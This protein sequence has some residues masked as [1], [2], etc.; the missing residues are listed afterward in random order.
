[1]SAKGLRSQ[2]VGAWASVLAAIIASTTMR[3]LAA[4]CSLLR[5]A[6]GTPMGIEGAA[7]VMVE[8]ETFM[9]RDHGVW[10]AVLLRL[11]D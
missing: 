8:A 2:Q 4:A 11:V 1:M 3:V 6:V 7:C 5:I 10:P 9:H